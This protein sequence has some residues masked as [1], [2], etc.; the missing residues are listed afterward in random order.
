MA[1]DVYAQVTDK[2]V[3]A[4][5]TGTRPWAKSWGN[6]GSSFPLRHCGTPYKGINV[7]LLWS[8]ALDKGYAAPSWMT[9]KQAAEL[10]GQVRKGEKSTHIVFAGG[11][12]RTETNAA[13]ED[14]TRSIP[15]LKGYSVFNVEQIDGLPAKFYPAP[16]VEREPQ[17]NLC[18][19]AELFFDAT[20][21]TF[22]HGGNSAFYSPSSDHIQLPN[23]E[24]FHDAEGYCAVKAHEL[25][26]WTGAAKR[27]DRDFS[28][29]KRFGDDA[30][31]AEELVAEIG[32]AFLCAA[33][34]VSAE[35]REDHAAYLSHWLKV[36][37]ADKRAIFTAASAAQAAADYLHSLQQPLALAA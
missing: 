19:R 3:A 27:L 25:I 11:I 28:K 37:K 8:E 35:P 15:F 9:Y 21:A 18:A 1:V 26:H 33:L 34:G 24:Q 4:L 17:Y 30:Y 16:V 36:L 22:K 20:G 29:S 5:E 6:A 2:I 12:Q 23:V 7:L 31:A 13:G 10:G 14:V 32:A